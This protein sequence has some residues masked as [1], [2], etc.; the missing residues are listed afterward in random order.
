MSSSASRTLGI[1]LLVLGFILL[2]VGIV[3]L[4]VPVH[5]L[6]SFLG[7]A[8]SSRHHTKRGWVGFLLGVVLLIVGGYTLSR[9]RTTRS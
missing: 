4:T 2:I 6:P 7:H 9:A 5:S 8:A 1:I 3:Y